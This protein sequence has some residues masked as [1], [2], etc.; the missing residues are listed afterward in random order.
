MPAYQHPRP[1]APVTVNNQ[2]PASPYHGVGACNNN[3]T[4]H[5]PAGFVRGKVDG[6]LGRFCAL[7]TKG[8]VPSKLP[9]GPGIQA[10]GTL[11]TIGAGGGV[12]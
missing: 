10:P 5:I 12:I 6:L 1:M 9:P 4:G 8:N 11:S 3:N 7:Q 2:N